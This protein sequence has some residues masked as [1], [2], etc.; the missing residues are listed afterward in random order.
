M[1]RRLRTVR[2][3]ADGDV[4]DGG[5]PVDEVDN[6]VLK[7]S[8]GYKIAPRSWL[9]SSLTSGSDFAIA[10]DDSLN[11]MGQVEK[12]KCWLREISESVFV[13]DST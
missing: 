6:N 1:L 10:G 12:A 11:R 4:C 9:T 2:D 13:F 5:V 7:S 3:F 8:K